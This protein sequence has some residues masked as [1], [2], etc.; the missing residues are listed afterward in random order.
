MAFVERI[1]PPLNHSQASFRFFLF[2]SHLPLSI[3][4]W[5]DARLGKMR[6][7]VWRSAHK[8]VALSWMHL[9]KLFFIL[10]SLTC[11]GPSL[12]VAKATSPKSAPY[13]G[14]CKRS[15]CL[16]MPVSSTQFAFSS[17]ALHITWHKTW[18]IFFL[19][20]TFDLFFS[21]FFVKNLCVYF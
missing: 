9:H 6:S 10:H 11:T 15:K 3:R 14:C 2:I 20:L 16:A 8:V 7:V 17:H 21:I 5:A 1:L 19:N 18:F 4:A 12:P 13:S